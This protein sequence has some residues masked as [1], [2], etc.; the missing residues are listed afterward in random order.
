MASTTLSFQTNEFD[1]MTDRLVQEKVARELDRRLLLD[2]DPNTEWI[3]NDQIR[4][5]LGL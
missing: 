3:S 1:P 4:K 5:E 2:S